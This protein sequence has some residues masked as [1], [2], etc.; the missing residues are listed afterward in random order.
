MNV[1]LLPVMPATGGTEPPF[2]LYCEPPPDPEPEPGAEA[3]SS[4]FGRMALRFKQALA[5]G[6]A[7]ERRQETGEP[8]GTPEVGSRAGR[9][10]KRKLAAAVAEQRLLWHLRHATAGR[11]HHPVTLTSQRA[12]DIAT[13]EFKK[14]FSK[15]RLWCFIDAAIVVIQTPLAF[16][17]GPN[18]LAYYF[19]FRSV[20]HFFSY[21]GARKGMDVTMWTPVPSQPL[22]EL[23]EALA[24]DRGAQADRIEAIAASLGLER[25]SVFMRRI[26]D[27]PRKT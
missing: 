14:D 2:E 23:Q 9:W 22:A 4:F 5:E 26:V 8:A 25:L 19:I 20:G 1:F 21:Q 15:H 17:P 24:L 7:E 11:L 10:L 12:L 13:G 16:L 6:E 27:R 18:F 3:K